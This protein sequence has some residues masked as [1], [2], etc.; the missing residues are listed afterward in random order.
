MLTG[1]SASRGPLFCGDT[2]PL[3]LTATLAQ[4]GGAAITYNWPTSLPNNWSYQTPAP[5]TGPS[6]VVVPS[7]QPGSLTISVTASYVCGSVNGTTPPA[8]VGI[9]VNSRVA[10]PVLT[11]PTTYGTP[12]LYCYSFQ[13]SADGVGGAQ[14]TW[15]G[16]VGVTFTPQVSGP[17]QAV[18][19]QLPGNSFGS[20]DILVSITAG[21]AALGCQPSA[22]ATRKIVL[23]RAPL[24]YA[25]NPVL[26]QVGSDPG[27]KSD[28]AP[29]Q[30]PNGSPG[31]VY[32]PVQ[33]NALTYLRLYGNIRDYY[34]DPLTNFRWSVDGQEP[35]NSANQT[36]VLVPLRQGQV[37]LIV[38]N[39]CG[40]DEYY[41]WQIPI[42]GECG[43][44][45]GPIDPEP[46]VECRQASPT[47]AYPNPA[48]TDLTVPLPAGTRGQVRLRNAQGQVVRHAP[49]TGSRVVF[50]VRALPNGLYY[51]EVPA[52]NAPSRQ[53]IQVQH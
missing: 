42:T 8:S 45:G 17:G 16:P 4:S 15:S 50:D 32:Q 28:P 39:R 18:T 12:P 29:P 7:G 1:V 40:Q 41:C 38:R 49:A 43:G 52:A 27:Y 48:N 31:T 9:L 6:V 23:H 51:L 25:T 2:A 20:G 53:S 34:G 37:C 11:T 24:N 21:N 33:C 10:T 5:R 30:D 3:T 35:A 19:V 36:T 44:G 46:C 47:S 13:A 14:F 22:P 26:L